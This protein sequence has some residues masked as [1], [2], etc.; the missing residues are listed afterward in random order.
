MKPTTQARKINEKIQAIMKDKAVKT[1]YLVDASNS[2]QAELRLSV[3][4]RIRYPVDA[5]HA[6]KRMDTSQVW[7][8]TPWYR[9]EKIQDDI[10]HIAHLAGMRWVDTIKISART[11]TGPAEREEARA[12]FEI[13]NGKAFLAVY[14]KRTSKRHLDAVRKAISEKQAEQK[15]LLEEMR[16][17]NGAYMAERRAAKAAE[18]EAD[19]LALKEGRFWDAT[20]AA[21]KGYFHPPFDKN[22]LADVS[23]KWRAA[24]Y[25]ECE[26]TAW[27]DYNK[28]WRHKLVGTGRAYLCGIDDNGDEWGHE[29]RIGLGMDEHG[30]VEL[31]A[32]VE[33]AMAELFAIPA[34]R[35]ASCER[36]GDL[37][38]CAAAIPTESRCSVCG[39]RWE[40]AQIDDYYGKDLCRHCLSVS[41][42]GYEVKPPEL[43]PHDGPWEVRESHRIEADGLERNGRWF[44][45]ATPI[46]V[47]HTSHA[48]VTLPAGEYRLY[49]LQV[50]DAD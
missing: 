13:D 46:T 9:F 7:T 50:A 29:L 49:T 14:R 44:R 17:L 6:P 10:N 38:F 19:A 2:T 45:S 40:P 41:G 20:P 42:G 26:S 43:H 4:F 25:L 1:F 35:L 48:P 12:R 32:D 24:L 16:A 21:I 11:K 37:L 18:R 8:D 27:K 5:L 33:D 30:N 23:E 34:S 3:K 15:T 28:N 36:Q 39:K 31:D 22:R 47:T